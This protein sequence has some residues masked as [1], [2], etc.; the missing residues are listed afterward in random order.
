MSVDLDLIN[1]YMAWRQN[2]ALMGV[3]DAPADFAQYR[4]GLERDER[5]ESALG[6][7]SS[8][9]NDAQEFSNSSIRYVYKLLTGTDYEPD[10]V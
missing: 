9:I 8:M 6:Y 1:D 3:K 10:D 4:E 2:Q 5:V 7:L